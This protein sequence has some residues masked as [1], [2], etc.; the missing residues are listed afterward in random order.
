MTHLNFLRAATAAALFATLPA[1]AA[2]AHDHV[3]IHDGYV[4]SVPPTAPSAAGY[5]VIDNH[6]TVPV[7]ITGVSSDVAAN[8]ML[9]TS[10]QDAQ[11]VMHMSPLVD[12][13][14]IPAGGT[15]VLQ[16]GADHIMFM[17]LVKPLEQGATVPVTVQFEGLPDVVVDLTVN[18][19][20]STKA[21]PMGGMDHGSMPNGAGQPAK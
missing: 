8:V 21:G 16:P 15:H 2:L 20:G 17:G 3:A 5:M 6:R 12:G 7:H 10:T 19:Q 4:R 11:G 9:H 13:I 18:H 14:T 1:G